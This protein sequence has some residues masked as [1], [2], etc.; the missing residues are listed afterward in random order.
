MDAVPDCAQPYADVSAE[1]NKGLVLADQRHDEQV[2]QG[3]YMAF[4]G[5]PDSTDIAGAV[6][7]EDSCSRASG[8]IRP[9]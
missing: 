5:T 9:F 4:L 7:G 6:S 3:R 8:W 1:A 2:K